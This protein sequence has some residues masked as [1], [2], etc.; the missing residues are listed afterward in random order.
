MG[1]SRGIVCRVGM[2]VATKGRVGVGS[3]KLRAVELPINVPSVKV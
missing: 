3:G 2:E 1:D